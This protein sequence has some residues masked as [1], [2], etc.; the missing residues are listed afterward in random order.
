MPD[1]II[2]PEPVAKPEAKPADPLAGKTQEELIAMVRDTNARTEQLMVDNQRLNDS[3]ATLASQALSAI[4]RGSK[5]DEPAPKPAVPIPDREEDPEGWV[6]H[7]VESRVSEALKA[8]VS[9]LVDQFR[10]DRSALFTSTVHNEIR[11]MR[12]DARYPGFADIEK[13]VMEFAKNFTAEQLAKPGSLAECYYRVL[14]IATAKNKETQREQADLGGGG[15]QTNIPTHE[16][17]KLT[18]REVDAAQRAGLDEKRFNALKGGGKVDID[19]WMKL[20]A[21]EGAA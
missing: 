14:G 12:S 7:I 15:R 10:N 13:D 11:A 1:P 2:N 4:N 17:P 9:P 3:Y 20:N 19:E 8:T 6:N 5:E 21:K 16:P 18:A